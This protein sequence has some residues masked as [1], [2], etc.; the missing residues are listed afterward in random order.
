M[1]SHT[2]ASKHLR[3]NQW[4]K[5]TR[6]LFCSCCT[7]LCLLS[8]TFFG[9]DPVHRSSL[10]PS[11]APSPSPALCLFLFP[12]LCRASRSAPRAFHLP[13]QLE[14][15]VQRKAKWRPDPEQYGHLNVDFPLHFRPPNW[16]L[17]ATVPLA[18]LAALVMTADGSFGDSQAT[19]SVSTFQ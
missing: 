13:P 5:E 6:Y 8:L 16:R 18:F 19:I 9:L 15:K 11:L 17:E 14:D 12:A 1:F 3:R 10:F 4:G 2:E 7:V